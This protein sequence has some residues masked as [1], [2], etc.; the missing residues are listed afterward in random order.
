MKI[1]KQIILASQ[2]PRRK[3]LLQQ[4]EIDF[5][6]QTIHT[7][8]NYPNDLPVE[9]VPAFIA[10]NKAQAVFEILDAEQQAD[11]IV[12]AA[13]TVVLLDQQ[14]I[15]KPDNEEAAIQILSA[16]SGKVHRVITG[17][18]IWSREGR[19]ELS[20]TTEVHFIPLTQDD[21]LHYVR[22]YQPF[23]KAGSYA[24]QE[25]IGLKG[26][27]KINGDFYN[28]MGLPV[29]KVLSALEEIYVRQV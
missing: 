29:S 15:G 25:W 6:V 3:H 12:I 4:A 13:D 1:N 16:L 23:D 24:I 26:I 9:Q 19:H 5:T 7:D 20:E 14:I 18:C 11:T 27:A 8:E 17:V 21:I 28:V 10:R 22:K 2:S